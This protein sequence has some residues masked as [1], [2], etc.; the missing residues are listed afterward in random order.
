VAGV[1][2]RVAAGVA[3]HVARVDDLALIDHPA[4]QSGPRSIN[5]YLVEVED[6]TPALLGGEGKKFK[7][8]PRRLLYSLQWLHNGM[9]PD[10]NLQLVR[11]PAL[12]FNFVANMRA[13][14]ACQA[15]PG[16][17]RP[18]PRRRGLMRRIA[19]HEP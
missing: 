18:A 4:D 14:R 8:D 9:P 5:C 12:W 17:T 10:F 1:G 16:P 13:R 19:Y 7:I 11:D 2:K 15:R 3:Q 6:Y